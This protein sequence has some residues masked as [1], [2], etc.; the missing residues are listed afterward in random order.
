MRIIAGK[1]GGR[2]LAAFKAG[3]IR[4]TTDRV[5]ESV[6][7]KLRGELEGARVLDLFS[8][9]GNLALEAL[10]RGAAFVEA[11]ELSKKSI[12]IIRENAQ[13][14]EIGPE[15]KIAPGDALKR[16]AR[17]E[18]EPFDL[19]L[20]DP[21]FTEKLA[22]A[23]LQELARSA[24]MGPSTTAVIEASSHERV[25]DRYPCAERGALERVDCRDYGD[26]KVS[27]FRRRNPAGAA[28]EK[29]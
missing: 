16:L 2:R 23:V 3:H 13:L 8:G 15:L 7:N 6:F 20:I 21:P 5:K 14:L 29:G 10:S 11:V 1:Y 4:P 12:A 25:D 27:F 19:I 17:A 9:T 18:G 26:K 28:I 24:A 22:H